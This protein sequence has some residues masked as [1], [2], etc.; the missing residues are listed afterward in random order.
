MF[1]SYFPYPMAPSAWLCLFP[2]L[3]WAPV[4]SMLGTGLSK[5]PGFLGTVGLLEVLH[6]GKIMKTWLELPLEAVSSA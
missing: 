5:M 3:P 2:V 1:L 4:L 6:G